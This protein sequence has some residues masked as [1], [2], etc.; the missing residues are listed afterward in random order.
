MKLVSDW[1]RVVAVSLSFWMQ[2]FGLVVLLVPEFLYFSTGQDSDPALWWWLG[3]LL[4]LA[5]IAG[6]LL[7]QE[8]RQYWE[9]LRWICVGALVVVFGFLLTFA[10]PVAALETDARRVIEV[11]VPFI[12][13]EEGMRTTAYRDIVGVPTIC[14]GSTRGVRMGMKKTLRECR[15]LL[16]REVAEYREG[17]H[18]YF[19][20]ETKRRR[21]TP[22]RDAAYTS[23]AFNCGIR[24]I[25]K[26]TA[27]RR[28]NNG[29]IAGG[30][31]ALGWWNKAGGRV[32][33][34]LV[35]RR[36]REQ[37]LCLKGL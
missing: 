1:R 3:V 36:K 20:G 29:D 19:T 16:R 22:E 28:L 7:R 34:G 15:D 5:G 26:S 8:L 24:A 2:V 14:A 23:L 18:H 11:A 12:E 6:R 10:A 21:L 4:L 35:N 13:K 17:L 27:T 31:A 9:V 25:G 32:I 30:C 33:R 37:A